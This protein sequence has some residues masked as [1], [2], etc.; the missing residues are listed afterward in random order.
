MASPRQW[1]DVVEQRIGRK[2]SRDERGSIFI[3]MQYYDLHVLSNE[4]VVA[5]IQGMIV[6]EVN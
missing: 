1:M 3:R 2:L 5:L 6:K 4:D